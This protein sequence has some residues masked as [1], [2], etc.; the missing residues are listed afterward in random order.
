MMM[1][2]SSAVLLAASCVLTATAQSSQTV[3]TTPAQLPQIDVTMVDSSVSPCENFSRYV[4]SKLDAASPIPPDEV[5][6][7]ALIK[8]GRQNRQV[9][10]QILEKNQVANSSRTP[11]EQKVGDFYA[12]CMEQ[13]TSDAN[14]LPAIAPLL[15]HINA[16]QRPEHINSTTC[17][18]AG[19]SD[20]A[21]RLHGHVTP[22]L[23]L[24]ALAIM[25]EMRLRNSIS[26]TPGV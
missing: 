23:S 3:S 8:M 13:A 17:R 24:R 19:A 22:Y 11:N 21:L 2:V 16:M 5:W 7:G 4:C 9:L 26:L 15:E 14:D 1:K 18:D 6:W 10:R 20:T 25:Q 12:S